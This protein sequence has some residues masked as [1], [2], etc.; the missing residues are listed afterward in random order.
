MHLLKIVT[1]FKKCSSLNPP[2]HPLP[3]AKEKHANFFFQIKK[4]FFL[5]E[6]TNKCTL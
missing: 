4:L 2:T 6:E 5:K 3:M 1:E